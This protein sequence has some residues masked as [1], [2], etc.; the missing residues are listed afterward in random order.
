MGLDWMVHPGGVRYR[1]PNSAN[2]SA[3]NS[4]FLHLLA[5]ADVPAGPHLLPPPAPVPPH[6]GP[7][8]VWGTGVVYP[9]NFG[10]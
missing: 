5:S 1:A 9:G 7:D 8:G 10:V 6:P 4:E 3:K 2:N